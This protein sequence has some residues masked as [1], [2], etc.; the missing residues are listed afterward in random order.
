MKER[1]D[2][3]IHQN[4]C[5]FS[6]MEKFFRLDHCLDSGFGFVEFLHCALRI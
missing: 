1:I 6:L 2:W 5:L 4:L 3:S